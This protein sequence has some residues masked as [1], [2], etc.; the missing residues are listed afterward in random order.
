MSDDIFSAAADLLIPPPILSRWYCNRPICD[1]EPHE[2]WHWCEHSL[3][4]PPGE[5][6]WRCRHA[7]DNQRPPTGDWRVWLILAGR[8]FGKTRCGAEWLAENAK[9]KPLTNWAAVAPTREDLQL[10]A[11][12]GDF[13]DPRGTQD[14]TY[15]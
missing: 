5:E 6:Y 4:H 1:G 13:W 7:R 12:E 10:T 8:G 2:G 15:R 11:F 14:D 9:S 3:P